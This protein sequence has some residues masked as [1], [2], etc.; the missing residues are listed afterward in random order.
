MSEPTKDDLLKRLA[1]ARAEWDT[2]T[3]GLIWLELGELL[4]ALEA[5][6]DQAAGCAS[7]SNQQGTND[8]AA[9]RGF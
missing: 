6:E 5:R 9:W 1:D 7:A 4:T 2:A 3:M 8:Q